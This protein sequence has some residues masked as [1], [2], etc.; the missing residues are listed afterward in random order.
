MALICTA[1][2][3]DVALHTDDTIAGVD[4]TTACEQQI[5]SVATDLPGFWRKRLICVYSSLVRLRHASFSPGDIYMISILSDV[6]HMSE[7]P[8]P[9]SSL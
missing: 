8:S 9:S 4:L 2:T 1:P 6:F 5:P 3:V 7:T